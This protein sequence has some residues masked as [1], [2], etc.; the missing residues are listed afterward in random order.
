MLMTMTYLDYIDYLKKI[1]NGT[2]L[3]IYFNLVKAS[4][5]G[6]VH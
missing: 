6:L 4:T 1:T 5:L 3:L 2:V